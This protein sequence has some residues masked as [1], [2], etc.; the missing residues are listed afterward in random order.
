MKNKK[1]F[2]FVSN[3]VTSF[4][5][6]KFDLIAELYENY[7]IIIYFKKNKKNIDKSINAFRNLNKINIFFYSNIYKL[8]IDL[9]KNYGQKTDKIF[10][11][12][13]HLGLQISLFNTLFRLKNLYLFCEGLGRLFPSKGIS[14]S[15]F[16]PISFFIKRMILFNFS[17]IIVCNLEDKMFFNS[18][19]VL[20]F[21]PIGI[22][23]N[24]YSKEKKRSDNHI[25]IFFVGRILKSKGASYFLEILKAYENYNDVKFI[26]IGNFDK[27][28][29]H[30]KNKILKYI[31][32]KCF[33][34][35][36][37]TENLPSYFNQRSLLV[38]PSYY[39][40]GSP[41]ILQECI[42]LNVP[43]I[44]FESRGSSKLINDFSNGLIIKNYDLNLMKYYVGKF[45]NDAN[46]LKN[47]YYPKKLYDI[48]SFKNYY[49]KF[50]KEFIN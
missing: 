40:E 47:L 38:F 13:F 6:F 9:K 48:I 17:K 22:N 39:G 10:V 28:N 27:F 7:E 33:N 11:N 36:P 46:F 30:I 29:P 5:N 18:N 49:K 21:G 19:K 25:Q 32:K 45:I 43:I 26:M 2:V 31:N 12:F 3:D 35:I 4:S 16:K 37:Y 50:Y 34:Y 1:K 24:Y 42:S 15:H 44:S 20:N 8:L 41:R 14:L 23:S